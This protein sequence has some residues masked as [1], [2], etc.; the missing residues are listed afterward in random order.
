[1]RFEWDYRKDAAN[2]QKHRVSFEEAASVFSDERA[3]FMDDPHHS[4]QEERYLLLGMG[5]SVRL[6]VVSFCFRARDDVIRI[7]SARRA[8]RK[9]Q[10]TY[11]RR[12]K[13]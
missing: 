4:V 11:V 12:R 8:S 5:A 7:I 1:M 10:W 3:L 2:Q 13:P 6:L 9:E